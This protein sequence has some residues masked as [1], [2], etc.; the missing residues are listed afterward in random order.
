MGTM[1]SERTESLSELVRRRRDEGWSLREMER[2]AQARGHRISHAQLA[3]YAAG[4]VRRMPTLEGLEAIAAALDVGVEDVRAASMKE[5][6]GYVP[7]ELKH[8]GRGSRVTAAMPP[9]LSPEEEDELLRMI[10]AWVAARRR[11]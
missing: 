2:R 11:K 6:W 7:R 5:F 3:D 9:D 4:V 10:E 1:T 8:R